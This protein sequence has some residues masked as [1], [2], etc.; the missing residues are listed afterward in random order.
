MGQVTFNSK[1]LS[2]IRYLNYNYLKKSIISPEKENEYSFYL[3][4]YSSRIFL[5]P[6]KISSLSKIWKDPCSGKTMY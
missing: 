5:K 3:S 1:Y 2:K 4:N 6:I